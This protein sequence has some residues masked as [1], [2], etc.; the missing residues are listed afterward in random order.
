MMQRRRALSALLLALALSF[1]PDA[2]RTL[3]HGATAY[4]VGDT[5]RSNIIATVELVVLDHEASAALRAQ[6][7]LKIPAVFRHLPAAADTAVRR[8]REQFSLTRDTFVLELAAKFGRRQLDAAAL[9]AAAFREFRAGFQAAN[10]GLPVTARLAAA[11]AAGDDG[12][13]VEQ[14]L[15]AALREALADRRVR[16][17][18]LPEAALQ[19]PAQVRLLPAEIALAA[20]PAA[21][22]QLGTVVNRASLTP[23][24]RVRSEI[25]RQFTGADRALGRFVA[26]LIEPD[27]VF[28]PARTAQLRKF[29]T[30][31]LWSADRYAAG[32]VIVRAG[33]P[34]TPPVKA[35]LEELAA[36][37]A[38]PSAGRPPGYGSLLLISV[39]TGLIIAGLVVFFIS[40]RIEPRLDTLIVETG[41][42]APLPA[43]ARPA[44][45]P[46]G[47][48]GAVA[49]P[50]PAVAHQQV[51]Q[52]LHDRLVHALLTQ[53]KQM[54]DVQRQAVAD[55]AEL[56]LRL[57][58]LQAPL[59]ARL[60]AYEQRIAELEKDLV[61]RGHENAELIHATIAL[62]KEKLESE[63]GHLPP[64]VKLN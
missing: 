53:R 6:A 16:A 54:I 59:Q 7:A 38:A 24:S 4:Q 40:R 23:V 34:I 57:A 48:A 22:E 12:S 29:K 58:K 13:A 17:D 10:K 39:S 46:A 31:G 8:L 11:W 56:E 44:A 42:A 35:A 19:G 26:G 36:K 2:A 14:E 15:I 41:S 21:W 63:R 30:A 49:A 3:V 50:D 45:L 27:C 64:R 37:T 47:E 1:V 51:Q 5:A 33:E 55:I 43:S 28:D 52:M 9:R 62:V 61:T 18:E 60:D 20:D 25:Q 32:Q